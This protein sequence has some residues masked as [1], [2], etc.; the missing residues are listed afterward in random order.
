MSCI[1]EVTKRFKELDLIDIEPE[2]LWME[3]CNTVQEAVIK[4]TPQKGKTKKAK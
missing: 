3:V 4:T 2:K 1:V